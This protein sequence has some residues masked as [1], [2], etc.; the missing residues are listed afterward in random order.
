MSLRP[1]L[2]FQAS[3]YQNYSD[4]LIFDSVIHK[5]RSGRFYWDTVYISVKRNIM[6]R[7]GDVS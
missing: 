2:F 4:D 3:M 1:M 5:R 6:C 7:Q